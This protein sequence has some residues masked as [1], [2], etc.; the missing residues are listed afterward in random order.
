MTVNGWA[1][2]T[3]GIKEVKVYVDD[4]LKSATTN[5]YERKD[6]VQAYPGYT[7]TTKPGFTSKVNISDLTTGGMKK[8][9]VEVVAND[10]TVVKAN[11]TFNL[12]KL[13]S[14]V[15]IDSP[16]GTQRVE[17]NKLTVSGWALS[18]SGV[19]QINVYVDGA[20]MNSTT[21]FSERK[22]VIQ[23]Y[24]KYSHITKPG[25][26]SIVDLSGITT[27]GM[28]KLEVE[29]VNNDGTTKRA[30]STFKL[31]RLDTII[32]VDNPGW[33]S[34]SNKLTVSGWAISYDEVSEVKVYIDGALRN[35]TKNL[36]ARSDVNRVY[37]SYTC[38]SKPGFS[39]DIDMS[40]DSAGSKVLLVEAILKD[41]T[42]H[43]YTRNVR[44]KAKETIGCIDSPIGNSVYNED[45]LKVSGW[46]LDDIDTSKVNVYVDDVLR[47][48]TLSKVQ[49]D[50]VVK[51]YP[52]YKVGANC[53]YSLNIN[54]KG[55][56]PGA[57]TLKVEGISSDGGRF[58]QAVNF[59]YKTSNKLI[60]IDPGHNN[61]GDDGAYSFNNKYSER[62][63]NDQ[64]ALRAKAKLEA[65]GYTVIFTRNPFSVD[66]SNVNTSL[67]NR[68]NIANSLNPLAFISIHQNAYAQETA[69]G[70]E[71][72]YTTKTQD[73][74]FP[75]QD[76][77]T[78]ISK[79][80]TL[81]ASIVS[82]ISSSTGIYNRGSKDG[83][84]FVLRNTTMPAV[85]VECGF[86]TNLNDVS[87]LS[88]SSYQ[89][90]IGEAIAAGVSDNF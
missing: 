64:I 1:L 19:K 90:K 41:G 31:D 67:T 3:S 24:P 82:K 46:I 12:E 75:A 62:E 54:I 4:K 42:V 49:R 29:I 39:V 55:L 11:S 26:T 57:H 76:K 15:T 32:T 16:W 14:I 47:G 40:K 58:E 79:S 77:A 84:L 72:Y 88:D 25:F 53:G 66:Y 51:V 71:V 68:V 10:G 70:T 65:K 8:L 56:S 81:A 74:G 38:A 61:G 83:N 7:K 69:H 27:N 60:V 80:Q 6:V 86:I 33:Y 43:K 22:D 2:S 34:N 21:S 48:T 13:Q 35:S 45:T 9:A 63:L 17:N 36:F 59:Y 89:D 85:L 73:N 20:P 37:P 5:F 28:K 78:K 30:S 52:G 18:S 50:D 23:A 44:F 87:K